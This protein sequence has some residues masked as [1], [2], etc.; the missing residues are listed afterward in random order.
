[1][2]TIEIPEAGIKKYMPSDLSECNSQ[3]YIDMSELIFRMICGQITY[4]DLRYHAVYKLLDMV[5]VDENL[6]E[7]EEVL[8]NSNLY[9]LSELIDS[10]FEIGPD[11]Q[12]VIKQTYI[13]NPIPFFQPLWKRYYGPSDQFMNIGFGEYCDAL[14]LFMQFNATGEIDLLYDIAAVLYRPKK[15]LHFV[16][17]HLSN[18]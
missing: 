8:K 14:R 4:E 10:F 16:T 15:Q 7:A 1:M 12:K 17:R 3:E 5:P 11:D 13:H 18:Y 9:R 2:R 6:V